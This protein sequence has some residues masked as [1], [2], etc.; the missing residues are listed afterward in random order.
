MFFTFGEF[1]KK[2]HIY[3][4]PLE[5]ISIWKCIKDNYCLIH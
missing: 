2:Y 5:I 1:E 3:F 4:T